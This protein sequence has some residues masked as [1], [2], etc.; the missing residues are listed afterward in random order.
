MTIAAA[1]SIARRWVAAHAAG[2][3]GY[4]GAFT[5]GSTNWLLPQAALPAGSDLDVLLVLDAP[6]PQKLGKLVCE[7]LLLEIS[8]LTAEEM[9][10]EQVL[11]LS[12][13]AGSFALATLLDDPEGRLAGLQTEVAAAY[14]CRRWV[15]RRMAFVEAKVRRN[16][17]GLAP[18]A[19]LDQQAVAW[20][21]ATGLTTHIVLVAGLRNPTVRGRYSAVRELL[22]D[23]ALADQ[24]EPLLAL[25]DPAGLDV[26]AVTAHLDRLSAAF[27][28]AAAVQRTPV[29]YAADIRADARGVAIDQ[30]YAMAARG[31]HREAIFWLAATWCRCQEVLRLDAPEDVRARHEPGFMALLDHLGVGTAAQLRSRCSALRAALG[32]VTALAEE[33][34]ARCAVVLD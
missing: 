23:V 15:R 16:L 10:A 9:V 5:H 31:E 27:E 7:G 19:P 28:D 2:Q 32:K 18:G 34:M 6:P 3:P 25:L 14:P 1:R 17:D 30:G 22:T 13:L 21:F 4:R 12:Y 29:P 26:A 33:V 20:L 8:Y 24:Y 11:G